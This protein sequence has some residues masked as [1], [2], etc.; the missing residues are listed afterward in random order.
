MN[1]QSTEDFE[2]SETIKFVIPVCQQLFP[3][4][5]LLH[6]CVYYSVSG[7]CSVLCDL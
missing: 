2:D 3:D 4:N 6:I 7:S 5:S 1:R